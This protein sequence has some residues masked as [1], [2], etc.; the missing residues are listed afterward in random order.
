[1]GGYTITQG[2]LSAGSNYAI[3][4]ISGTLTVN[5]APLSVSADNLGKTYGAAV[6]ALTYPE[7]RL[8]NGDSSSVFSGA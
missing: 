1:M 8:V 3:T 5:P 2:T 6:P 7:S 4:Y